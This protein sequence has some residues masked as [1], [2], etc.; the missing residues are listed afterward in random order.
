MRLI[1]G[2]LVLTSAVMVT[3]LVVPGI[4]V[5]WSPGV[6]WA[7]GAVF[8]LVNM[9][10]G[11]ILRVV[12][13]PLLVLTLGLFSLVLNAILLLVTDWLLDSLHVED[14]WAALGGAA[15]IAL[16]TMIVEG[17]SGSFESELSRTT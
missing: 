7:I 14:F 12:S 15:V 8:A 1:L 4:D 17:I 3:V 6:Y 10:L 16:V 2:W 13:L 11:V 9:T 5:D